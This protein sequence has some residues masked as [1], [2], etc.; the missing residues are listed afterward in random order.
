MIVALLNEKS[1]S[2]GHMHSIDNNFISCHLHDNV[3][4]ATHILLS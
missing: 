1:R 3:Y 2:I 4:V